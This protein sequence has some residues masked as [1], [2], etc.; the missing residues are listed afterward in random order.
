MQ[1][2]YSYD[3]PWIYRMFG[4]KPS[5]YSDDLRLLAHVTNPEL[6]GTLAFLTSVYGKDLTAWKDLNKSEKVE[7]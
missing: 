6:P 3:A 4:I 7:T 5:A 1:T 2:G